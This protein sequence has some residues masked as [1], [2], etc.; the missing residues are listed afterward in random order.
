M[1]DFYDRNT[2]LFRETGVRPVVPSAET[3]EDEISAVESVI[4]A[5]DGKENAEKEAVQVQRQEPEDE[6]DGKSA[7]PEYLTSAAESGTESGESAQT[8]E[9]EEIHTAGH[10]D[11]PPDFAVTPPSPQTPS[12]LISADEDLKSSRLKITRINHIEFPVM[13]IEEDVLV[14]DVEPDLDQILNVEARPEISSHEM[15]R[16]QEGQDAY[17]IGG[18]ISVNTLYLPVSRSGELISMNSRIDFRRECPLPEEAVRGQSGPGR[19]PDASETVSADLI[20]VK[21]RVINERKI[22]ISVELRCSVKKYS[23]EEAE[24]LE[25]VRDS[26]LNLRKE[27]IYFTDIAQRRRDTTDISGEIVSEGKYAGTGKNS[28]L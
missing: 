15:I 8:E 4:T 2:E 10:R 5:E 26:E 21:A 18:S 22:R 9:S 14:P 7:R 16:N 12:K 24:F 11:F 1:S 13:T 17:K 27:T 23:E 6:V 20:S 19:L 25:G 3:E 28:Q